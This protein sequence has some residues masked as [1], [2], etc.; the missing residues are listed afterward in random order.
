LARIADKYLKEV[1][2]HYEGGGESGIGVLVMI[3]FEWPYKLLYIITT[4]A[5]FFEDYFIYWFLHGF[6]CSSNKNLP[7]PI[8]DLDAI[9]ST[10]VYNRKRYRDVA[11]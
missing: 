4:S 6:L 8:F 9:G 3:V 1:G 7:K 5:L 10:L 2:E 11:L